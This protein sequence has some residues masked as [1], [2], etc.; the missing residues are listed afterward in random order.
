MSVDHHAQPFLVPPFA[1]HLCAVH[2]LWVG[3]WALRLQPPGLSGETHG[4]S[5]E[6]GQESPGALE[7]YI[8][9][10]QV[11]G[12]LLE[13]IATEVGPGGLE[14]ISQVQRGILGQENKR[15]KG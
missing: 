1:Q 8:A 15:D 4:Y 14:E 11:L 10:F 13:K 5:T 2:L 9:Y 7:G 6:L 3:P 12:R